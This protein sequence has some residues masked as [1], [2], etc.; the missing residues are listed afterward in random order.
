MI[1]WDNYPNNTTGGVYAWAKELI[2]GMPEF[3]FV[4]VNCLSNPNTNASYKVPKQVTRVIEMPLFGCQRYEEF[5]KHDNSSMVLKILKTKDAFIQDTFLPAYSEFVSQLISD[6]SDAD[7][8]SSSV[9][10][11]HQVLVGRDVKKCLE[12]PRSFEIFLEAFREDVL[13]KHVPLRGLLTLFQLVQRIVQ[14]LSIKITDEIDIV[15]SSNAWFPALVG[16][17]AKMDHDCPMIVTE[18]GVAFKDL[19]LYQRLFTHDEASNILWKIFSRNIIRTVCQSADVVSPVCYANG[20]SEQALG[21]DESKIKVIYNG[22]DTS[23]FRPLEIPISTLEFLDGLHRDV[24]DRDTSEERSSFNMP[25]QYR[26]KSEMEKSGKWATRGRHAN[27]RPTVVYVGRIELLKDLMNLIEAIKIVKDSIPNVLCL[28][29]GA[30][31]DLQYARRCSE[32]VS[33]LELHDNVRFMGKTS[34]PEV[35]YNLADVVVLSS[36]REG[37]PYTVIEAMAC[38]KVVVS[39]DV[40]GIREAL[41]NYGM[42]VKPRH[43][44]ELAA[45]ITKLLSDNELRLSLGEAAA[46]RVTNKFSIEQTIKDYRTLY[47]DLIENSIKNKDHKF[48]KGGDS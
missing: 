10:A 3:K 42:L 31:T 26:K 38:A 23:R 35:A 27:R 28:I 40:G 44:I 16:I 6:S 43:R 12:N 45:E 34:E 19:L 24:N 20:I 48:R 8:L 46:R 11:L 9:Y 30:S 36:V 33:E 29:Y 22:V 5:Y 15:H 7:K 4:V 1:N 2:A 18:H 32:L 39:T 13:Y 25:N 21:V 17:C 41:E 37:F 14:I 47:N